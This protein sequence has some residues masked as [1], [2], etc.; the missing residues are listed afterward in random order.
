MATSR[1]TLNSALAVSA[2]WALLGGNFLTCTIPA[3]GDV[4][5]SGSV[6]LSSS[7]ATPK[8]TLG[9]CQDNSGTITLIGDELTDLVVQST[10]IT[11][12]TLTTHKTFA[13]AAS[14]L[15]IGLCYK[16]AENTWELENTSVTVVGDLTSATP[17]P[18]ATA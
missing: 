17:A 8:I 12:Y 16:T 13:S 10:A 2:S 6:V 1:K 15:K 5:I 9:L 14:G 11:Y 18:T 7:V 4:L 3:S